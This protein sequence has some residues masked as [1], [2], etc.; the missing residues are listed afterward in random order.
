MW[1][2][3]SCSYMINPHIF[4]YLRVA[5]MVQRYYSQPNKRVLMGINL[6]MDPTTNSGLKI[7]I[8]GPLNP[9]SKKIKIAYSYEQVT[10]KLKMTTQPEKET[11]KIESWKKET[12]KIES[13]IRTLY[14]CVAAFKIIT[15]FFVAVVI[16]F[17]WR[18]QHRY[19]TEL[20]LLFLL[21]Y[22]AL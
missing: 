6:Q 16:V 8:V 20:F 5:A 12:Y 10:F 17:K 22:H 14:N 2:I 9:Q 21:F 7:N 1:T 3:P 18:V 4:F 11:H 13:S 19:R 15:A